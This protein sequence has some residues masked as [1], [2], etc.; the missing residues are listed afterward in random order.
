VIPIKGILAYAKHDLQ[1]V[2]QQYRERSQGNLAAD[3]LPLPPPRLRDRVHGAMD[4]ASFL[5]VGAT[6]AR[7]LAALLR[8]QGRE[9][10]SFERV[11]D[12]G[13]G[14]GRT[15]RC[16]KERPAG[17]QL[18]GTDIDP[19]SI[20]WCREHLRG[21]AD[22]RV[23]DVEPP[24]VYPDASFDLIYAISVF[25][26]IDEAAQFAWLAELRRVAKPG[27]L[28]LLTVHGDHVAGRSLSSDEQARLAEKGFSFVVGA[29]GRWKHDGLPD[30]YQTSFHTKDYVAR[31]WARYFQ[32]LAHVD[33]GMGDNQDAVVLAKPL[34]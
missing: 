18:F 9:L 3:G 28:L 1:L 25:T 17:Q 27:A 6:C 12:F 8:Q 29:T 11:L 31:E 34:A 15:L 26:H 22:W 30:S 4:R 23:N 20:G 14:C 19:Q 33:R 16:F 32:V 21:L 2:V 5:S 10:T 13:C 7:D 24:L